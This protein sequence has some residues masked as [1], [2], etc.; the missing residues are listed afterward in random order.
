M[1]F[2]F[3]HFEAAMQAAI[4]LSPLNMFFACWT[5]AIL[6]ANFQA[7]YYSWTLLQEINP[8]STVIIGPFVRTHKTRYGLKNGA[9]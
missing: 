1:I 5:V 6:R 9:T 8:C 3:S 7:G 2:S 4:I